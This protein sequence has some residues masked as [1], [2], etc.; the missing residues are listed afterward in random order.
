MKQDILPADIVHRKLMQY[1]SNQTLDRSSFER[2]QLTRF[3]ALVAHAYRCS[4][5]YRRLIDERAIRLDSCTP[6]DFPVLTK[7]L[8]IAHFDEIVTDRSL[9]KKSVRRFLATA[10][11]PTELL[12]G[13]YI[14]RETSGTSGER[15]PV[16]SS[17]DECA[18]LAAQM[19]RF[20]PDDSSGARF[21]FIGVTNRYA[22]SYIGVS[23]LFPAHAPHEFLPIDVGMPLPTIVEQLNDFRPNV[24]CGYTS[25]ILALARVPE[26]QRTACRPSSINCVGEVMLAPVGR[27]IEKAF[28]CPVTNVYGTTEFGVMG[29]G[30]GEH[31]LLLEDDLIYEFMGNYVNVTSLNQYTMPLI[32][33]TL[34]DALARRFDRSAGPYTV[35]SSHFGRAEEAVRLLNDEGRMDELNALAI[36]GLSLGIDGMSQCQV[37]VEGERT[38]RF[39]FSL[40]DSLQETQKRKLRAKVRDDLMA[41]LKMK[42]MTKVSFWLD[43]S[44]ASFADPLTGKTRL[45]HYGSGEHTYCGARA[46]VPQGTM[47]SCRS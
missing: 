4:P 26:A 25:A 3:R 16:V 31:M 45:V 10:T 21:A 22:A 30:Q 6:Q 47:A 32:R 1:R 8:L 5:Y 13:R 34:H 41:M 9:D 38:I 12:H 23:H 29:I 35:I 42:S 2:V 7:A 40:A 44:T 37:V 15:L 18:G 17:L 27:E 24:L 20:E 19:R 14:V 33:Y 46:A 39:R 11:G 36:I 43:E 28:A